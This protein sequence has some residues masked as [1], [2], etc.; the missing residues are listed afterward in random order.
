MLAWCKSLAHGYSPWPA[1]LPSPAKYANTAEEYFGGKANVVFQ[2]A[3]SFILNH[4]R[5]HALFEHLPIM[6]DEP[7]NHDLRLQ[8][9]KEADVF[10]F[11]RLVAPGLSDN[12][13]S[14]ESWAI[15][16][17]SLATF[18]V[19]KDP[20][21]ALVSTTHPSLH[22]RVGKLLRA[23]AFQDAGQRSYFPLLCR[24]VLQDLNPQILPL[25]TEFEDAEDALSDALARLDAA[26]AT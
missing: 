5:A 9:E 25:T 6:Q 10:A 2:H 24:V 21:Q 16:A 13:K 14:L 19:Y 3:T 1:H 12:E 22:H 23:L 17:V 8:L 4:E 15:L 18:Y 26:I 20:R 11:D 7:G